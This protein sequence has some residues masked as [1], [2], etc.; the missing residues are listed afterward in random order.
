MLR[1]S[2]L[3]LSMSILLSLFIHGTMP[4]QA[5]TDKAKGTFLENGVIYTVDENHSPKIIEFTKGAE[6]KYD[7]SGNLVFEDKQKNKVQISDEVFLHYESGNLA[8][9]N[10]SVFIPFNTIKKDGSFIE[11]YYINKNE[12][13]SSAQTSYYIDNY[14]TMIDFE[15]FI[16]KINDNHYMVVAKNVNLNLNGEDI[17]LHGFV[18]VRYVDQGVV[19]IQSKDNVWETISDQAKLTLKENQTIHLANKFISADDEVL[20]TFNNIVVSADDNIEVI[21]SEL[22][23]KQLTVPKI[24]IKVEDGKDGEEGE[25]GEEGTSG[26][27]GSTGAMGG[28]GSSSGGGSGSVT[29]EAKVYPTL[30]VS[31]WEVTA[32]SL[33]AS[34]IAEDEQMML[35][36]ESTALVQIARTDNGQVVY[37][38]D[39]HNFS[40]VP[41][42]ELDT[43]DILEPDTQYVL[44]VRAKYT[45]LDDGKIYEKDFLYKKFYT[46]STGLFTSAKY[47]SKK[48][49]S[50]DITHKSYSGVR[51]VTAFLFDDYIKAQNFTI[52]NQDTSGYIAKSMAISFELN[53]ESTK[54]ISF[55][56]DLTSRELRSNTQYYVRLIAEIV[57]SNNVNFYRLTNEI[58]QLKTTKK[59]AVIGNPIVTQNKITYAFEFKPSSVSD[60]DHGIEQFIYE[61]YQAEKYYAATDETQLKNALVT[62]ITASNSDVVS[63]PI[64]GTLIQ[65]RTNY[66]VK[67]SASFYNNENTVML[68]AEKLS[69]EFSMIGVAMPTVNFLMDWQDA[70]DSGRRISKYHD[71]IKGTIQV[72]TENASVLIDDMGHPL[73]LT[74]EAAGD[75]LKE[76]VY[77]DKSAI[78]NNG[79][80]SIS[81][82][83]EG[84]KAGS[85][86]KFTLSGYVDLHDGSYNTSDPQRVIIGS[87]VISTAIAKP[88]KAVWHNDPSTGTSIGVNLSLVNSDGT[89]AEYEMD[90][91]TRISFNLY[92]GSESAKKLIGSYA[93]EDTDESFHASDFVDGSNP[94]YHAI[95]DPDFKGISLN[96]KLFGQTSGSLSAYTYTIE[97]TGIDDYTTRLNSNVENV[98]GYV[99]KIPV[100]NNQF[101]VT[102]RNAPPELPK[103]GE[104]IKVYPI[105]N[106][107]AESMGG[108]KDNYL[109]DDVIVGYRL[110]STYDNSAKLGRTMTF[111]A[112]ENN[113][114]TRGFTPSGVSDDIYARS[115]LYNA[116]GQRF[117]DPVTAQ[118]YLFTTGKINFTNNGFGVAPQAILFF[119][120]APSGKA[121]S[122]SKNGI[123]YYYMGN[124]DVGNRK[125]ANR[126]MQLK[127]TYTAE[128]SLSATEVIDSYYPYVMSGYNTYNFHMPSS[129]VVDSPKADPY[130]FA[131]PWNGDKNNIVW[132]YFIYDHDEALLKTKVIDSEPLGNYVLLN[133][134]AYYQ[135]QSDN[136][137]PGTTFTAKELASKEKDDFIH[138]MLKIEDKNSFGGMDSNLAIDN[139]S[140]LTIPTADLKTTDP[141]TNIVSS[142]VAWYNTDI[143]PNYQNI[144][145]SSSRKSV[146]NST[147]SK[148]EI[149]DECSLFSVY[150]DAKK[151]EYFNPS[152]FIDI[153]V[154]AEIDLNRIFFNISGNA[155]QMKRIAAFNLKFVGADN[156]KV[157]QL[158]KT[159]ESTSYDDTSKKISGLITVNTSELADLVNQNVQ[160]SVQLYRDKGFYGIGLYSY[161]KFAIRNY[162]SQGTPGSFMAYNELQEKYGEIDMASYMP[163]LNSIFSQKED[164][165]YNKKLLYITVED[166][167]YNQRNYFTL[168][169]FAN[170][171]ANFNRSDEPNTF[172][173]ASMLQPITYVKDGND[174]LSTIELNNITP[175]IKVDTS[176]GIKVGLDD[177]TMTI[178]E[179][180]GASGNVQDN[181]VYFLLE[182]I[183]NSV[184]TIVPCPDT[185]GPS[186]AGSLIEGYWPYD[187]SSVDKKINFSS[188]KIGA[189]YQIRPYV[190]MNGTNK[191]TQLIN[192]YNNKIQEYAFYTVKTSSEVK[193]INPITSIINSDYNNKR[194]VLEY[195]LDQ[196]L[197]FKVKYNIYSVTD[198][199][200][201]QLIYSC[202]HTDN[203]F[204]LSKNRQEFSYGANQDQLKLESGKYYLIEMIAHPLKEDGTMDTITSVGTNS[205]LFQTVPFNN[206]IFYTSSLPKLDA[207]KHSLNFKITVNDYGRFIAYDTKVSGDFYV[208]VR[209]YDTNLIIFPQGSN[210]AYFN[211]SLPSNLNLENLKPKTT[212]L[213]S[214]YAVLDELGT[215]VDKDGNQLPTISEI[216]DKSGSDPE[217]LKKYLVY[218]NSAGTLDSN[219]IDLGIYR[220]DIKSELLYLNFSGA[221]GIDKIA[222]MDCSLA[223]IDKGTV[224]SERKTIKPTLQILDSDLGAYSILLP[225]SKITSES[226]YNITL[227]LYDENGVLLHT[228]SQSIYYKP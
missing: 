151:V 73:I 66:V 68:N 204:Q 58:L 126:G 145:I 210:N 184:A 16:W 87:C 97:I 166:E 46:D 209:E 105:L 11:A 207:G 197:G 121:S 142:K 27:N 183:N 107:D 160:I 111:Y 70:S 72:N 220:V 134:N 164:L 57:D 224:I 167:V 81:V 47:A 94:I 44:K 93:I 5:S 223:Y 193:F 176:R 75:Y 159:F 83:Q 29:G 85:Q 118:G 120:G 155:E 154:S 86:Y 133:S 131:Y 139:F 205:I 179:I 53:R 122:G 115:E 92:E 140:Y 117:K 10:D 217:L 102:K 162:S 43:N 195:S 110:E 79:Q 21:P 213:I 196:I 136:K 188:L 130:V 190:I 101:V 219:G 59:E 52:E 36:E 2:K 54:S 35:S 40:N 212:Y 182:E 129:L 77:T 41:Q 49:V 148:S 161:D 100:E 106:I 170:L 173:S 51:Q 227:K 33:K 22:Y 156:G 4:V 187:L 214:I 128:L 84:L 63:L 98:S 137:I 50:F 158:V 114:F 198:G 7:L 199:V 228:I 26:N 3:Y 78:V 61:V 39:E 192:G 45:P 32:T 90:T 143:Y 31:N 28:T 123:N 186:Y 62:T 17:E 144:D 67:M 95:D 200:K 149:L 55:D 38:Y 24:T 113:Y 103:T 222:S 76:I 163:M 124:Y 125:G 218:Q 211:S 8:T 112:F 177:I 203:I 119:G 30:Y 48:S 15:E 56:T 99:N 109:Q 180:A 127:F 132:K 13:I 37:E 202:D 1:L 168:S 171:Y 104:G 150:Y 178:A 135:D 194:V 91:S 6:Y 64:D 189:T 74:I 221:V 82:V 152:N 226:N 172:V 71:Q 60:P 208:E 206:P 12:V 25:Q 185:S 108:V 165:F 147:T 175:T 225:F 65:E 138:A 116:T 80:I 174:V 216:V 18:E 89:N 20:L 191:R 23:K 19:Q 157:I 14:G 153:S 42:L 141:F 169:N 9:F 88:V 69:P 146:V 201:D 34:L 181:K 96:E 215:G